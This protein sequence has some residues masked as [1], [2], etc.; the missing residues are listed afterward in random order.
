MGAT[1]A[2]E[3]P[4]YGAAYRLALPIF[5]STGELQTAAASL[6]T[7]VSKDFAA[8]GDATNEASHLGNGIYT[9]DLTSTEMTCH[10]LYGAVKSDQ[11]DTPFYIR[12]LRLPV[13]AT[14]TAQAGAATSITLAAGASSEDDYHAGMYVR[15]TSGTGA[16]QARKIYDYVG[17]T[18]VATVEGWTTTPDNTSVYEILTPYRVADPNALT[19]SDLLTQ[20]KQALQDYNLDHLMAAAV[21]GSDV[22]DNSVI[23]QLVDDA[24]TADWDNY[25][26]TTESLQA[27]AAAVGGSSAYIKPHFN[28]PTFVDRNAGTTRISIVLTDLIDDLPSTAEITPGT[29]SIDRRG[30][31]DSAWSAIETDVAM[32]EDA[33]LIY[34]DA[35]F[36]TGTYS[37]GDYIRITLKS[38]KVAVS[39]NDHEI[40]PSGGRIFY[41]WIPGTID[42]SE[43]TIADA[44]WDEAVSGH[45]TNS[46]FGKVVGQV[47]DTVWDEVMES[48][49]PSGQQTAREFMRILGAFA[50]G[51]DATAQ[52]S[53]DWAV[54]GL[55]GQT[56]RIS[57]SLTA[58]G[59]RQ[60]VT[61]DG[62]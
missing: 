15:I 55:D 42:L 26:N 32:S 45:T 34:Y 18:K 4:I 54:Y 58:G 31:G 2:L 48:G 62:S 13:V 49:A 51:K 46:T 60:V 7:E 5:D 56:V 10:N 35:T 8:F 16:G 28:I 38:Q 1:D 11:N 61:V 47:G 6:D 37:K 50:A 3:L 33:G 39:G 29:I 9:I 27:I 30:Q 59:L 52:T 19:T 20:A 43:A 53:T 17:S 44:V 36:A 12:P 23:A 25:D 21:T 57:G 24:A 14:G 40:T 41:A 22:V